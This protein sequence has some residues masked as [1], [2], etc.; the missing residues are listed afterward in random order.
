MNTSG[1]PS[2]IPVITADRLPVLA[3]TMV[4]GLLAQFLLG[5]VVSGR[6]QR[7]VEGTVWSAVEPAALLAVHVGLGAVLLVLGVVISVLAW[8][9]GQRTWMWTSVAGTGAVALAFASGAAATTAA[10]TEAASFLMAAGCAAAALAYSLAL[11][12]LRTR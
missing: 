7:P 12:D 1:E 10:P 6:L 11:F 9:S 4:G 8:R 5:A 3:G 2:A